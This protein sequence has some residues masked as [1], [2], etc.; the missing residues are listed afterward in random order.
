MNE[1][2]PA[3]E[4][5]HQRQMPSSGSS[6]RWQALFQRSDEP[7]FVLNRKRALV[8]VNR[9]W[10]ALTGLSAGEARQVACRR[11]R[12]V[13]ADDSPQEILAHLLCP[14]AEVLQGESARARRLLPARGPAP[15]WWDVEF[16]PLHQQGQVL[17]ILGRILPVPAEK[18]PA[19]VPIPESLL[20]LRQQ[21]YQRQDLDLLTSEL[22]FLRRV[23]DQVRLA[24]RVP[25]P[26]LLV[27]EPGTGK[28][29]LARAIHVRSAAREKSFAALDC[30]RLPGVAV[31]V[32]L[33]GDQGAAQRD[34]LGTVYLKEPGWL[35]REVQQHLA[36][37]L[38]HSGEILTEPGDKP[39]PR[40]LAGCCSDPLQQVRS[41]RLLEDLFCALDTLRLEVPPLRERLVDLPWLVERCL[42]RANCEGE[43]HISGLT[44]DAWELIRGHSWPGNLRELYT[45]LSDARSRARGDRLSAADLPAFMRLHQRLDQEPGRPAEQPLHLDQVLEQVERRLILLAL[46]RTRGNKAKAAQ[47]LDLSRPRLLRRLEALEILDPPAADAAGS[48]GDDST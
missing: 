25:T 41:G 20:A 27:G 44:S 40:I 10:E 39:L 3:G 11:R 19:A 32:L 8:F 37:R 48:Q 35:P 29:T 24:A 14:P 42:A 2:E 47:L 13:T 12:Q 5:E 28:L 15:R 22:P 36:E 9:A 17:A 43:G 46:K 23:A 45:V 31:A 26:V 16:F 7:L 34:L 18:L 4:D 30:T 21:V 38:A 6:F 33:F 1:P